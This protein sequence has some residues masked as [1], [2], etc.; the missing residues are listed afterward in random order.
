MKNVKVADLPKPQE[1]IFKNFESEV[2]VADGVKRTL[3]VRIST[4]SP[5]RS[6]DMVQPNGMI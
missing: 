4:S 2:K 3:V 6:K 5:D 1:K